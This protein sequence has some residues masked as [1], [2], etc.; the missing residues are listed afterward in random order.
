MRASLALLRENLA[1][2]REFLGRSWRANPILMTVVLACLIL[3]TLSFALTGLGLRAIVN[4]TVADNRTV[5]LLGVA[6]AAVAYTIDFVCGSVGFALRIHLVE[7]L[8]VT[9][10]ESETLREVAD[11]ETIE[12]LERTDYLDRISLIRGEAWCVVDSAWAALESVTL[13]MRVALMLALLGSVSPYLLVLLVFAVIPLVF[14]QMG[15]KRIRDADLAAAEDRRLEE[16]LLA[17]ATD[18]ASSKEIRVSGAQRSVVRR[19]RQAWDAAMTRRFRA[20]VAAAGWSVAGWSVFGVGFI[21]AIAQVIAT[22][23]GTSSSAGNLVM[24]VTTGLQLRWA[25]E[26]AVRRSSDTG[27]YGRLLAPYRWLRGYHAERMADRG[28]RLPA[29][30][31]LRDG[32][33][34]RDLSFTYPGSDAVALDRVNVTLPAGT[35]VAVVGEYGSGKTTLIKLLAKLYRPD[36]GAILVD[37]V[38]LADLDTVPW[39]AQISAA[40]QDFGRYRTTLAEAIGLGDPS[41]IEDTQGIEAAARGAAATGLIARLPDG[42]KTRLGKQFGGVDLSEGQWQ[43]VALARACMRQRP[44]LFVL[45]EPT[46]SLDAPS[47]HAIF[48]GYMG[49]AKAV[50]GLTGAITVVVSHRFSTVAGADLILVLEDGHLIEVGS[51]DTLLAQDGKYASLYRIQATAYA[52]HQV[53]PWK[54]LAS[55]MGKKRTSRVSGAWGRSQRGGRRGEARDLMAYAHM[56]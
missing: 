53:P 11:I 32:I 54:P 47:E 22:T 15:R 17:L 42:L 24:A 51:H 19:Q 21:G 48:E 18:P 12:H 13:V 8:A 41:R 43:K 16:H 23:A 56:C 37:G 50:A 40:F 29:P 45:D 52:V 9:G 26:S 30:A 49:R 39:R 34:L 1:L 55:A 38:D 25:V 33:T 2:W 7:R 36:S 28:A 44:L 20:R 10:V 4:G 3:N 31:E 6:G 5:I 14:E 35:V 46:A 27:G